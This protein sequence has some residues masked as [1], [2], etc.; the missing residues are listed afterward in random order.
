MVS[1]VD[2]FL[3]IIQ[4]SGNL[5]VPLCL[6]MISS[7]SE[8]SPAQPKTHLE[9][10]QKMVV[11]AKHLTLLLAGED[12]VVEI[13]FRVKMT[14]ATEAVP[15]AVHMLT[16]ESISRPPL[17]LNATDSEIQTIDRI[18]PRI[19]N[20]TIAVDIEAVVET[21]SQFPRVESSGASEISE[22]EQDGSGERAAQRNFS[23]IFPR[24]HLQPLRE[25]SLG[26]API[27]DVNN[28]RDCPVE[29]QERQE[30]PT[31]AR[32]AMPAINRELAIRFGMRENRQRQLD[33]ESGRSGLEPSYTRNEQSSSLNERIPSRSRTNERSQSRTERNPSR[34]ERIPSRTGQSPV[35]GESRRTQLEFPFTNDHS[36]RTYNQD[37][38][39]LSRNVYHPRQ[40]EQSPITNEYNPSRNE[41]SPN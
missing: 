7:P 39:G 8:T 30:I 19:A 36:S 13:V 35:R 1:M 21:R 11:Q 27:A 29:S 15:Q 34:N 31:I 32:A 16:S 5:P 12:F 23:V 26:D 33:S 14:L 24:P 25:Q 3:C 18:V 17:N 22:I 2:R 20:D 40:T 10:N 41:Q 6:L 4:N 37:L 28:A 38:T 9:E